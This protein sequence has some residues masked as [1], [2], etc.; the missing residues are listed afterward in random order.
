MPTIVCTT[1]TPKIPDVARAQTIGILI[2]CSGM[3][4]GL[5][6]GG[7]DYLCWGHN[8]HLLVE[9]GLTGV[10]KLNSFRSFFGRIED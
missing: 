10:Q 2:S 7:G 8:L 5:Q 1:S 3:A 6:I 4:E 9:I